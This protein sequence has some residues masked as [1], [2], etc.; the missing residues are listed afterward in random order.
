MGVSFSSTV[1][2]NEG[3]TAADSNIRI[4]CCWARRIL[5]GYPLV[6][7]GRRSSFLHLSLGLKGAPTRCAANLSSTLLYL[8]TAGRVSPSSDPVS[9]L[10]S[11]FKTHERVSLCRKHYLVLKISVYL[12]SLSERRSW[13]LANL[14]LLFFFFFFTVFCLVYAA[15]MAHIR[16]QFLLA[17]FDCCN[18]FTSWQ[19]L[20]SFQLH[21]I[22][23]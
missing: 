5:A 13:I 6:W 21:P 14:E 3:C 12:A 23:V 11:S 2:G 17:S 19:I 8:A 9:E 10:P 7:C 15:E 20:V 4:P 22:N 1:T 18:C 16:V